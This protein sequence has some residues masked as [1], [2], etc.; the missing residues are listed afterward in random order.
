M[1]TSASSGLNNWSPISTLERQNHDGKRIL[2]FIQA[3]AN[4]C[5][6][7][8]DLLQ[9]ERKPQPLTLQ[10]GLV[11]PESVAAPTT[12]EDPFG[13]L[14]GN[15][16]DS[17]DAVTAADAKK[18]PNFGR[19]L[20]NVAHQ[21]TKS[22]ERGIHTLA[23]KADK[24][25]SRDVLAVGIYDA[26]STLLNATEFRTVP[27][28]AGRIAFAVPVTCCANENNNNS[29]AGVVHLKLWIRS[30]AVLLQKTSKHYL[31]GHAT[32]N[33]CDLMQPHPIFLNVV[34]KSNVLANG[35]LQ[36]TVIPDNKAPSLCGR[37]WSLA[38]PLPTMLGLHYPIL[39]QSYLFNWPSKHNATLIATERTIES[40]VVLPI[41]S[42]FMNL[43]A[44]ASQVSLL[45]AISTKSSIHYKRHDS[46][47]G[48]YADVKVGICYLTPSTEKLMPA[49]PSNV[50]PLVT[51]A[52]QRPDTIFEVELLQP[53][54]LPANNV[55]GK[56]VANVRFF[57]KPT[58]SDILPG[59]LAA[60]NGKL[61]GYL[62]GNLH[63]QIIAPHVQQIAG[64]IHN[65]FDSIHLPGHTP[66]P[67]AHKEEVWDAIVSL[68]NFLLQD[69]TERTVLELP[70]LNMATGEQMGV[71][72]ITLQV[73]M[74]TGLSSCSPNEGT[75]PLNGLCDLMA[76]APL[77]DLT[78]DFDVLDP[79]AQRHSQLKTMG[80]FC[81]S[82]YLDQHIKM[83]RDN[84]AQAIKQRAEHYAK[85]LSESPVLAPPHETKT[86]KPF[87]PS[88][89]RSV[90][91]LSGLP[92]NVHTASFALNVMDPD[93]IANPAGDVFC[94]T[95]CGAPAD[96]ARGYGHVFPK[97]DALLVSPVGPVS[98]GLRRLEQKRMEIADLVQKMQSEL[99][100]GVGKYFQTQRQMTPQVQVN[101]VP[102]RHTALQ[103]LRWR[104]FESVQALHHLNW[105]CAVR[106]SNVFSQALGIAVTAYLA[107][108]SDPN[109]CQSTWPDL[110][111]KHGYLISF[112]GLLSAA[113]NELGMIEDAFVGIN[114]LQ[115]V[116]VVIARDDGVIDG[117]R[118][119]I[120]ASPY[121][122]WLNLS[123][124]GNYANRQFTLHVG[125]LQS[126]Y[127]QRI[128]PSLKNGT[129]IRFYSLLFEVGV[130]IRQWGANA[131]S[132]VKSQLD[133][134][135]AL[136]SSTF[137]GCKDMN[138]VQ[139]APV[140][141]GLIDDEDDDVGV[142]DEDVLVQLNFDAVQRLN[143]YACSISPANALA[144]ATKMHPMCETLYDHIVGSSGKMNHYILDEAAQLSQQ[145]G[146]GGVV[147]CKSGKDRTAMHVT[148][149]QAQFENRYRECHPSPDH[150]P[151][152]N[153][154]LDDARIIRIHGTR[155]P[156]CQK[157]VGES[158]Y[159]FNAL[160]VKFMPD[161]L[162]PP[163]NTLAGFLKGGKVFTGAR[164]ES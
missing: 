37:G 119:P 78:L 148:Y 105:Q 75:S 53:A 125:M 41:A 58:K 48:D 74:N 27:V 91:L 61:P 93:D 144:S 137:T 67:A 99:I 153:A 120:Q 130:D 20:K 123:T 64:I 54:P 70:V 10:Q 66:Q 145:L 147:F 112:E 24:N 132:N 31:L 87:R 83:Y 159:A 160:Q 34:L 109:K 80:A 162:K 42:A 136:N 101:H 150:I 118:I 51:A 56:P 117:N 133:K 13:F 163:M 111:A 14:H 122:K 102:A 23:V 57:P 129:P 30:G 121:L 2:I 103:G 25:Y 11:T 108:L 104:I 65:P 92:F 95:T 155:L 77:A 59:I 140:I 127:D 114:M 100:M 156:V 88:S 1:A 139:D 143:T 124:T 158:K 85:A 52:W 135:A 146:G 71:L 72:G 128:P 7:M 152:V 43:C 46:F 17:T 96:H 3:N 29:N 63:F 55:G 22:L 21:T 76:L 35:M 149:K 82:A 106:R 81:T 47:A 73:T 161:A 8:E 97:K 86:P 19:F 50:T 60:M 5:V 131:G 138:A 36:L 84:D 6:N 94:N 116:R 26:S 157:N 33:I 49:V 126:Y 32:L 110:W 98:G 90:E 141:S 113:G 68:E 134:S 69:D 18:K 38:D 115:M 154:L 89:S 44:K 12:S 45:H 4:C 164:I 40:T 79:S 151:F 39:D 16:A 9:Q 142:Q 62:L 28:Q 107:S 15:N